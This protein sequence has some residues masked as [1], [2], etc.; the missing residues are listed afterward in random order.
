MRNL[1]LKKRARAALLSVLAVGALV[2]AIVSATGVASV[3]AQS[4]SSGPSTWHVLVGGQSADG[5]IQAE[6][7]YPHVITIDAG[8]TVVWTLN[9][10]EGH[11]VTFAGTCEDLSCVPPCVFQVNTDVSPCGPSRYD[12]HTYIASSGRK[13]PAGYN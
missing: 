11:T 12:G 13:V 7:Y 6:G 5:A 8:D 2:A 1:T 3:H 4:T 9:T 10:G